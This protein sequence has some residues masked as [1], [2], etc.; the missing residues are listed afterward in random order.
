MRELDAING[1]LGIIG[2]APIDS[3][4]D[5]TVNEITDSALAK[6]TLDEVSRD[7]QAEGWEWNTER[8]YPIM[9]DSEGH[10]LLPSRTL[11]VRLSPNRHPESRYVARGLRLY[12]KEK[13]TFQIGAYLQDP[14]IVDEIILMLDWEEIP[15]TAQQ[16]VMIRAGRIFSNRYINSSAVYVYTNQ[17]EEYARAMMIRGE[18]RNSE[19]NLL[20][21]NDR[22]QPHGNSFIPSEGTRYRSN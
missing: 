20:W 13:H 7:V 2:E 9:V 19:H 18:E 12:D 5:I 3:V 1:L 16:Y 21:G 8:N 11:G 17:D 4:S 6:R 15:H 14:I 10:Y 22:G